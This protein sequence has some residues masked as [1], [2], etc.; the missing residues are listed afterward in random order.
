MAYRFSGVNC[1]FVCTSQR[2]AARLADPSY[3][4]THLLVDRLYVRPSTRETIKCVQQ[5]RSSGEV[6]SGRMD[7]RLAT[8]S[9]LKLC[10]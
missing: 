4:P 3:R 9:L 8:L 7:K 6:M 5:R 10:T 1:L 2:E